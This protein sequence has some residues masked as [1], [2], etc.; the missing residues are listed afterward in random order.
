MAAFLEKLTD[1]FPVIVLAAFAGFAR[2]MAGK[3]LG[4]PYPVR[5]AIPEIVLAIFS[6]L[7]VYWLT[8]DI[9]MAAGARTAT[10]ALAGYSARSVIPI[11]NAGFIDRLKKTIGR[12]NTNHDDGK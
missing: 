4:E 8:A 11:L 10:I 12:K 6:G 2:S 1:L 9:G 7:L 5:T 3:A